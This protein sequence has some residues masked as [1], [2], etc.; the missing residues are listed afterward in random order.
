MGKE[1]SKKVNEPIPSEPVTN[2]DKGQLGLEGGKIWK[3][4]KILFAIKSF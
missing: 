4:K 3:L 2:L 1:E